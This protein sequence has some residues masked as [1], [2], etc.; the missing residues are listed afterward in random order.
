[1]SQRILDREVEEFV[2]RLKAAW[3][4]HPPL[5][6]LTLPEARAIAEKV[7]APWTVGGPTMRRTEERYVN[8]SDP[9]RIRI[10]DHGLDE[11]A[12]ALV[13]LHGGGFTLFSLD[14]HDRLMREYAAAGGFVVIGVDYPLSPEAKY[15]VALDQLVGFTDWLRTHASSIGVD[16]GRIAIGG[17]SA[18]ANLALATCLRLRD[19]DGEAP[20]RAMLLNY[21]CFTAICSDE[22][23]ATHGGHCAV[24][25]RAEIEY[26]FRN[27]L[28]GPQELDDPYACPSSAALEGLPPA[29]LLIPECDI[30][31][32]QSIAMERRMELAGVD[33]TA[34]LYPGAT[35]SFLEAMS[36]SRLARQAI[37]DS[38][39]WLRAILAT[40]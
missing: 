33:V 9:V 39:A 18:G 28:N 4:R 5:S 6:T 20:Y 36:I 31:A 13:Y 12:P 3:A 29:F 37:D 19:K 22:A 1:M 17:D 24:L 26:F 21:G 11:P 35:H 25:D 7:R 34:K 8:A 38:A 32:E 16:A 14:T 30:L 2:A 10:Y 40:A 23:E 15:P 27:Y